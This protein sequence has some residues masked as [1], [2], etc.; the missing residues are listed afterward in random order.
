MTE[1]NTNIS[2]RSFLQR[3]GKTIGLAGLLGAIGGAV[4][5]VV[6]G[7]NLIIAQL[8]KREKE[9]GLHRAKTEFVRAFLSEKEIADNSMDDALK[10]ASNRAAA[11]M[12][13]LGTIG[14]AALSAT[15][16]AL[17]A[18][19]TQPSQG[20]SAVQRLEAQQPGSSGPSV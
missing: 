7:P 8:E 15:I 11:E 3:A 13:T 6:V 5:G 20:Q 16:A 1:E 17:I 12:M 18:V 4:G 19:Y 9:V 2:R 14:S 10:I